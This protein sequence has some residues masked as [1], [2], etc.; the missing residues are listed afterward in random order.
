MLENRRPA[1]YLIAKGIEA[2]RE[3]YDELPLDEL[4]KIH[5]KLAAEHRRIWL[6][7]REGAEAPAEASPS[8]LDVK[9]AIAKRALSSCELCEWRCKANR[10]ERVG[11]CRV[12]DK[13]MVYSAFLHIG[14]EAP[15]VPSGTIFYGGCPFR[16]AF[17]QNWEISQVRS[18]DYISPSPAGLAA[19]QEGLILRGARN[20]NH[21]GGEPTPHIPFILE[22]LRHMRANIPQ[23]WNSNMYMTPEAMKL[24]KDIIDI[25]LPDFKFGNDGCAF[26]LSKVKNYFSVVARN[27]LEA[28]DGGLGDM[29]VRHLVMPNHV[30]CCTRAALEWLSKN[31]PRAVLNLMDQY[32]PD[33]MVLREPDKY[34]DISRRLTRREFEAAKAIARELGYKLIIEDLMIIP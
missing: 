1:K 13:P 32:H 14:E 16:C 31:L 12:S 34:K 28:Y 30:E 8:Y 15:L 25:W 23:L 17:C 24:I 18:P 33:H 20:I 29:I 4:W 11:I 19:I 10:R 3:P 27:H 21:V 9:I 5:D 22:S 6:E 26:R 7:V 2:P